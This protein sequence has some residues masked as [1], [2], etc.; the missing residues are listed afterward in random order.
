MIIKMNWMSTAHPLVWPSW[1]TMRL[2]PTVPESS[3]LWAT[4]EQDGL[5]LGGY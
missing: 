3:T 5:A 2:G 4:D 1:G